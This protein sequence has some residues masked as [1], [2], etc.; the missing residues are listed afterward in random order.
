MIV[1]FFKSGCAFRHPHRP[2]EGYNKEEGNIF[3]TYARQQRAVLIVET[4]MSSFGELQ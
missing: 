3:Y 2:F 1:S 4:L